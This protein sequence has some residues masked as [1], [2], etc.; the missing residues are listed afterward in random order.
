MRTFMMDKRGPSRYVGA[1][2]NRFEEKLI[3]TM[4]AREGMTVTEMIRQCIVREACRPLFG[5]PPIS[6]VI[7]DAE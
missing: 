6:E 5:A 3:M 2:L 4:A 1:R 7:V